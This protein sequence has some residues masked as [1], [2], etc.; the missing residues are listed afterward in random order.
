MD[1]ILKCNAPVKRSCKNKTYRCMVSTPTVDHQYRF[2]RRTSTKLRKFTT[3]QRL[4]IIQE[5]EKLL[6]N[7]SSLDKTVLGFFE[8]QVKNQNLKPR[9]R[10]YTVSDKIFAMTISKLSEPGLQNNK[11]YNYMEGFVDMGG[12]NRRG[13]YA[14]HA[15]VFLIK[16]IKSKWKQPICYTFCQ[17]TTPT[18]DLVALLKSLIC[19]VRRCGLL[20]IAT[21]SDQG[22][23]NQAAIN[24]LLNETKAHLYT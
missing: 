10:R 14:D 1:P 13:L 6:H 21:I 18:A 7:L 8:S 16:G 12:K 5:N 19:N 24:Y 20:V 15:L 3:T 11:K 9:G 23:T 22:G 4:K 17:R 2:L